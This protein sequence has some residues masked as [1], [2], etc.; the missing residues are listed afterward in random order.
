MQ[1]LV[2]VGPQWG[3]EA[4]TFTVWA[5]LVASMELELLQQGA[6]GELLPMQRL[7]QAPEYWRVQVPGNLAGRDYRFVIDGS[8]ARPDPASRAQR[9]GVHG[10]STVVDLE[11]MAPLAGFRVP[12]LAD[13]V[14]YELH[15]G[16]FTSSG[17]FDGVRSRL[18]HLVRLG[19]DAVELMPLAQFPGERNWGYDGVFPYAVQHSYGGPAG[20]R[21]LVDACHER[22]L[23]VVL[24]VVYN[25]LGPE[26]NYLRDFAPYFTMRYS[27]PWGEALNFDGP[28]SDGV[29]NYFLC[30]A[31]YWFER[32]GVD[33]LRI[34]AVHAI[35]DARPDHFL[36]ELSLLRDAFSH[37]TGKR[38]WLI[39]ESHQNDPRL[40][41]PTAENGLGM[42]A[43]WNDDFH[44]ALHALFTGE[45][46]GYYA[47][48]GDPGLLEL[49]VAQGFCYTG[50]HS[51][52]R[53]RRHGLPAGHLPASCFVTWL[54][55]HDMIGNRLQGER[56][57]SLLDPETLRLALALLLLT[58]GAPMLF[59]GEEWGESAPFLYFTS[60]GDPDLAQAV[61]EG[62]RREFA[63]FAW[64]GEPPDPQDPATFEASR[65][66][67]EQSA[68][69][70]HADV[71]TLCSRLLRL[72]R[73]HPALRQQQRSLQQVQRRGELLLVQRRAGGKEGSHERLCCAF[74]LA[75]GAVSLELPEPRGLWRPLETGAGEGG[76]QPP[77]RLEGRGFLVLLEQPEEGARGEK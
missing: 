35:Y 77:A 57:A 8:L 63:A 54:Q 30:N 22:G 73:E 50:Q 66:S 42:D 51:A 43:V 28:H 44:H 65:P 13:A 9:Q 70:P 69:K 11:A 15:V 37:A 36:R 7:D 61:R 34:D 25:H 1:E 17:D 60:H 56:L 2:Q 48:Y 71:L 41:T 26:G 32:F 10:P 14:I 75:A 24:D 20:L 55:T 3:A 39:A 23:A 6:R 72:R 62:R 45:R 16:T 21:R 31:L 64:Q 19:V 46:Q 33:G 58:P 27:T 4:T 59:M 49:A 47:D 5:P 53:R 52:Y 38:P 76:Q 68:R 12:E 67:W 29:R 40:T 74:N 18:D